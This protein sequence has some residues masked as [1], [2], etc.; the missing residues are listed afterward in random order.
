MN[1]AL[2]FNNFAVTNVLSGMEVF[3]KNLLEV[4]NLYHIKTYAK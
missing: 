4:E 1:Q 2:Q 3:G